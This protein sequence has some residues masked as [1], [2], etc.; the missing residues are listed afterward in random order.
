MSKEDAIIQQAQ[1]GAAVW[2][3][4]IS[5]ETYNDTDKLIDFVRSSNLKNAL[6]GDYEHYCRTRLVPEPA[7][8]DSSALDAGHYIE[9]FVANPS[10]LDKKYWVFD[11]AERPDTDKTMAAK[12]NKIWLTDIQEE[13]ERD[14]KTIIQAK[15]VECTKHILATSVQQAFLDMCGNDQTHKQLTCLWT[16]AETRLKLRCRLDFSRVLDTH[17]IIVDCKSTKEQTL[18]GFKY[19]VNKWNYK[20]QAYMQVDGVLKT[21]YAD[22]NKPVMFYWLGIS[23]A[24]PYNIFI[25]EYTQESR[26]NDVKS[27]YK[28]A[29]GYAAQF[30]GCMPVG[31]ICKV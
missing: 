9:D 7:R 4:D 19:T 23:K 25:V 10:V 15:Q 24:W 5:D 26:D 28:H 22:S 11:P 6:D 16:D 1:G 13:C 29:L 31:E 18:S 21:G 12:E 27:I 2:S 3:L 30:D 20:L 14:G 17:T 8:E